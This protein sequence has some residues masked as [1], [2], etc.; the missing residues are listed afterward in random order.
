M[1]QHQINQLT[2]EFARLSPLGRELGDH[3]LEQLAAI[4][5]GKLIEN[6][7]RLGLSQLHQLR[8]RV[9]RGSQQSVCVLMYQPPLSAQARDRL[10]VMRKTTD[11]FRIAEHDLRMRGP[12]EVMGTRQTGAVQFRIADLARDADLLEAVRR[13][14]QQMVVAEGETAATGSVQA[15]I[16]RWIGEA[17]QYAE[18]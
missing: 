12:G 4:L 11:G 14:A 2:L 6:A 16:D 3:D 1:D 18:V 9:G 17:E 13:V 7:E 5:K 15:L 10:R 8:G